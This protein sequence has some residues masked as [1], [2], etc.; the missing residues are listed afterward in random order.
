MAHR[1]VGAIGDAEAL[2]KLRDPLVAFPRR[3][4]VQ[5][6]LQPQVLDDRELRV[7]RGGLED[8]PYA[9][10]DPLRFA[11]RVGAEDRHR[12]GAREH[13]RRHDAKQRR[14]AAAVGAEQRE[15][16]A[17]GH[18]HVDAGERLALAVAVAKPGDRERRV[19]ARLR[20]R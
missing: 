4:P 17:R 15:E 11:D 2:E 12:A 3:E 18:L 1:I 5:G 7:E 8:D 6:G 20:L 13:E 9:G 14:L 10:A 19:R 16:L